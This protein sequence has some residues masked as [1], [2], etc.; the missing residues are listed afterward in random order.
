MISEV[1][2]HH[3]EVTMQ[4]AREALTPF[5]GTTIGVVGL[6][7][8]GLPLAVEFGRIC[9]TVGFDLSTSK[10]ESCRRFCD[11]TGEVTESALRASTKLRT[12]SDAAALASA[13][14]IIVAVP[15]P[16]DDANLPD[17]APLLSACRTI[18]PHLRAGAIV[19]FESTVYPGATEDIC[20]PSLREP[21][22]KSGRRTSS[23]A[24]H[25]NASILPKSSTR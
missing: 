5:C 11:P 24:I 14:M 1:S 23:S 4:S 21:P 3:P 20:A 12:T 15:T 13:H 9:D 17:F 19:V 10:V 2:G 6:R 18:G 22:E 25:S 7:Y 16:V 8:V